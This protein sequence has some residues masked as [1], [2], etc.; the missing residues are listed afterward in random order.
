MSVLRVLIVEDDE[1]DVLITRELLG[2]ISG[3][4]RYE[5]FWE[6]TPEA[7]LERMVPSDGAPPDHDLCLLDYR[8]GPVSGIALLQQARALNYSCPV[9]LLTGSDERAVDQE[10]LAAGASDY[11][12]KGEVTAPLLERTIRYARAQKATETELRQTAQAL[13]EARFREAEVAAAIQR[14]LLLRQGPSRVPAGFGLGV[15]I[16]GAE[17]VTGDYCD[18]L[19]FRQRCFDVVLGDVMGKGL[20]AALVGSAVKSQLQQVARRLISGLQLVDRIPEPQEIVGALQ[21]V[22]TPAL[23]DLECFVTLNYARFELEQNRL[24]FV[25]AGHPSILHWSASTGSVQL[26]KGD[27]LPLG[28]V[29]DEFYI[30]HCVTFETGDLFVFYSDGLTE[31][32]GANGEPFGVERL[33]AA[34]DPQLSPQ[35]LADQLCSL[36]QQW[37]GDHGD[38]LTCIVVR[39]EPRTEPEAVPLQKYAVEFKSDPNELER[40]RTL[41]EEVCQDRGNPELVNRVLMGLS[42]AAGNIIEHAYSNHPQQRFRLEITLYP[43]RLEFLFHDRGKPFEPESVPPPVFDG[44]QDSGFGWFIVQSCF[45]EVGYSRDEMGWNHLKL[46]VCFPD[47]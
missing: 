46:S 18:F 11:L 19:T 5:V 12:V 25:D 30:Q 15:H 34:L 20:A 43:E 24:F 17:R 16:T 23:T 7:A 8:L 27:N 4:L 3:E 14:T 6:R 37:Q 42:E 22:L 38:D 28:I 40:L 26:L 10:A 9:I 13:S 36:A 32:L 44:S 35:A 39:I 1:E 31:A 41:A 47:T 45:D 2:D 29:A 33:K 21:A